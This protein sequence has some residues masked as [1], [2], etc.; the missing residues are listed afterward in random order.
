MTLQETI[1][2]DLVVAMKSKNVETTSLLRVVLG[3]FSTV[4]SRMPNNTDKVLSDDL[5]SKEIRRMYENAKLMQNQFEM[6]TL[7]KYLPKMLSE[8]DIKNIVS[9][10]ISEN[11]FSGVQNMGKVMMEIKKHPNSTMIDNKI[12]SNIVKELLVSNNF[13][14]NNIK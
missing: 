9:K 14:K 2:N 11:N 8:D 1:K 13:I 4:A 12:A 5:A 3:E 7:D 10:I 6:D